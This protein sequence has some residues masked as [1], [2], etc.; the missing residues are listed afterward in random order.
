MINGRIIKGVGGL[1][2]VDTADGIYTCKARGVFRIENITPLVGDFV[3]VDITEHEEKTGVIWEIC[4]RKSELIRPKSANVDQAVLI[5]SI[6]KPNL[7]L[8]LMD[9]F[10]ISCERQNVDVVICFNKT[11]I[12]SPSET[13]DLNNLSSIYQKS[14]F[15]V[16]Q[17]SA[18]KN[19]GIDVLEE[20]LRN[21]VSVF[22]G[23]SG[24]GKSSTINLIC[25]KA[26]METGKLSEK[27]SRGKHTTRHTELIKVLENT[28]IMDSPGFTSIFIEGM[29]KE[30]LQ[31]YFREFKDYKDQ[32]KFGNCNHIDEPECMVKKAVAE[33]HISEI[34]YRRY[35][36]IYKEI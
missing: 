30:E 6:K 33:G 20:S 28:Y 36:N 18:C 25:P 32:C 16:F 24:A 26:N 1:Y 21:K 11:D 9:R 27:I 22:A 13:E 8:D 34:R 3:E 12:L 14:G 17:I 15:K 35:V 2:W 5:F 19:S 4:P 31:N 29:E 7:N 23:P 10:I